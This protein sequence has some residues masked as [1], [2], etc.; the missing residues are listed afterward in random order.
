VRKCPDE[1]TVDKEKRGEFRWL[2]K[3]FKV[4]NDWIVN[5]SPGQKAKRENVLMRIF[6]ACPN[7]L[8][9]LPLLA[10]HSNPF[11]QPFFSYFTTKSPLRSRT[12]F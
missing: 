11:L 3:A 9:N 6:S 8:Y 10:N 1:K 7:F 5:F 2:L 4:K 12:L